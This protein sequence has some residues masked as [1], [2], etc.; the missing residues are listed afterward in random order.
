MAVYII[1][2][3]WFDVQKNTYYCIVY[4]GNIL[5]YSEAKVSEN[6]EGEEWKKNV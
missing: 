4:K 5:Y 1:W 6:I 2:D 3:Y